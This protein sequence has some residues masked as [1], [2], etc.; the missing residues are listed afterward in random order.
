V[1]WVHRPASAQVLVLPDLASP[2]VCGQV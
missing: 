1:V 2:H